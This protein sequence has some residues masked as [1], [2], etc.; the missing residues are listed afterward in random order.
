[1]SDP[2]GLNMLAKGDIVVCGSSSATVTDVRPFK[3]PIYE[4]L[5]GTEILY[6]RAS[7]TKKGRAGKHFV[8][9]SKADGGRWA[10]IENSPMWVP[11]SFAL[12]AATAAAQEEEAVPG[13]PEERIDDTISPRPNPYCQC[14]EKHAANVTHCEQQ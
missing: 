4:A 11:A 6:L 2:L 5:H 7:L 14:D 8:Q 10:M 13:T 9:V 12:A 1:M 3:K